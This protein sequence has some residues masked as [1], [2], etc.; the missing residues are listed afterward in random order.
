M[1]FCDI[2]LDKPN[3]LNSATR[4]SLAAWQKKRARGKVLDAW[5]TF[6]AFRSCARRIAGNLAENSCWLHFPRKQRA[7]NC[8]RV[9][10]RTSERVGRAAAFSR[11]LVKEKLL[12]LGKVFRSLYAGGMG[13]RLFLLCALARAKFPHTRRTRRRQQIARIMCS[14][15]GMN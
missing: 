1:K 6:A 5:P 2:Y 15:C 3:F 7:P 4:P 14:S 9:G 8:S 11:A 12:P 10:G 13:G